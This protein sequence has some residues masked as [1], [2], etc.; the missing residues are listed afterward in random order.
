MAD[1]F[2]FQMKPAHLEVVE[3]EWFAVVAIE[4]ISN[5]D[6]CHHQEDQKNHSHSHP[7]LV[8]RMHLLG[9]SEHGH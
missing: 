5:K 9:Q 3:L 7:G 2:L 6:G 8:G 1:S 4:P